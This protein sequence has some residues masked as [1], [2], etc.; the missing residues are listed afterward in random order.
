[1]VGPSRSGEASAVRRPEEP[2]PRDPFSPYLEVAPGQGRL[3]HVGNVQAPAVALGG[4]AGTDLRSMAATQMM[5]HHAQPARECAL[6]PLCRL[7]AL[8]RN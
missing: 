7:V 1:V 8:P 5:V 2:G 3:Q 4:V 6:Q